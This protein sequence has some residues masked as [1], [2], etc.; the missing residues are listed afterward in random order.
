MNRIH[1]LALGAGFLCLAATAGTAV[2]HV[3]LEAREAPAGSY[4]KAVV[5]V[6]HGCEGTA[7][8][9]IRVRLPEGV[10]NAKPMPKPGWTLTTKE[11]EYVQAYESHGRT[12]TRGVT[13]I[14]WTGGTL[15]DAWYDE[16]VFQ[17]VLPKR[18][19]GTVLYFPIVQECEKGVHRWIEIPEPGK[20]PADYREPAPSLTLTDKP[21]GR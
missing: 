19:A 12:I 20:S 2:A 8:T 18:P 7:T 1:A 13:E 16:F 5:K 17:A 10:V 4:Y 11:G 14:A 15:P 3:T 21:Q 6:P 9:A